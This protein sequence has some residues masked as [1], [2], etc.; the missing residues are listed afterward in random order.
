MPTTTL[1]LTE[2]EIREFYY[3]FKIDLSSPSIASKI[4][5][6]MYLLG[7]VLIDQ[8]VD[9]VSVYSTESNTFI[10][11]SLKQLESDNSNSNNEL[12]ALLKLMTRN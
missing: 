7:L 4:I 10:D 1:C 5:D 12:K 2:R 11:Y 3:K 6:K 9:V 8:E